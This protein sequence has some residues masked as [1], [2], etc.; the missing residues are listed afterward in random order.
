RIPFDPV[1]LSRYLV[2]Q[3]TGHTDNSNG[4]NAGW[5]EP[6]ATALLAL[7]GGTPIEG[8]RFRATGHSVGEVCFHTATTG[9]Q[10]ILTHPPPARPTPGKSSLSRFQLAAAWVPT[11]GN[12]QPS[13]SPQRRPRVAQSC[14][15]LSPFR[16]PPA[17]AAISTSGSRRA[18]LSGSPAS[19]P[20]PSPA[21]F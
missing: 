7:A 17:P 5:A 15:R 14:P 16:R 13:P 10:E 2:S 12:A 4:S 20:G 8:I 3:M 9:Y 18:A 6:A 1:A 11:R 19:T 21:S